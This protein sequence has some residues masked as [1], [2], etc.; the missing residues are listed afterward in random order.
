MRDFRDAKAMAH[1]I[2]AA[3]AANGLKITVSQSLEL[4]AKA[5]GVA[6]WNTLSA[7]INAELGAP[8]QSPSAPPPS[9]VDSP[10]PLER[11]GFS[12]ELGAT[13]HRA[14][15]S[16]TQ[17]SHK[18]TTLEHLLLALMD[19]N[20]ASAVMRA[21]NVDLDAMKK[22]LADHLDNELNRQAS[23]EA[24]P[25]AGFQRVIQRA[26]LHVQASGRQSVTGAQVLVAIF[27]EPE[28]HAAH[29]LEAQAMTRIDAVNF[30]VHGL[31]KRGGDA[32]A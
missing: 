9:T 26:A 7:A 17:R 23:D 5:F 14:I 28:S 4:I 2:R 22:Q 13:L 19:D 6:D 16:A 21:C 1:T 10:S 20:D 27:S 24:R 31:V 32:A 11:V 29:L 12:A 18:H 25:T 15:T 3:L 8:R 30:I